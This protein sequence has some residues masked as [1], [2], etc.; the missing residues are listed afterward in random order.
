MSARRQ[1]RSPRH[2]SRPAGRTASLAAAAAPRSLEKRLRR[3]LESD[4]RSFRATVVGYWKA[5]GRS[6]LPWR[7]TRDPY[8]ILVSEIMLQQTQV[9]RVIPYF[10]RW[11]KTYPTPEALAKAP[12][13]EVL[14]HWSGLGYNRR[15]KYLHDAAAILLTDMLFSR[16]REKIAYEE[17]RKLPG[18][19]EYTA[20]AVR[21][22]AWN[23][24][25]VLIETNVR[26]VFLHHFF[27]R[28]RAVS[29]ERLI[30]LIAKALEGQDPRTWYAAL[31]DYGTFLK[32]TRSNP[33][34]KSTHHA[35]QAK[36]EGSLRQ[37]RGAIMRAHLAGVPLAGV[38]RS[39][40]SQ[41]ESAHASLKVEGLLE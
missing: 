13:S 6:H 15:A 14:R 40:P 37:V 29:D 36:F 28:S 10:E 9:D 18:V 41:F 33:S 32:A 21:V 26:A 4:L 2:A 17:L 5:S 30:P 11:M 25:E 38:R 27:P 19:G 12:L 39:F 24:S 34:R 1:T 35:K 3:H 16:G 7:K 22:F 23:E 8:A 20:K 31:M